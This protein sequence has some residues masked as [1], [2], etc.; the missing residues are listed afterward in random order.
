MSQTYSAILIQLTKGIFYRDENETL[1]VEL[2]EKQAQVR[3][4]F[5]ALYLDLWL[6]E[7]EGYAFLKPKASEDDSVEIPKLITRRQLS[8]H[9]SL[10]LALLRK[11]L[12]EF[13]S[14]GGA[15]RLVL[16][17]DEL[18]G[19]MQT[20]LP[21]QS[22]EAKQKDQIETLANKVVELGF[23]RKLKTT[24]D[25]PHFE[26]QRIIKAFIDA[27]WLNNFDNWLAACLESRGEK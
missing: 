14:Q 2:I 13:D 17:L 7:A 25:Q 1:W 16:S 22:N 4:Y 24:Q 3:D 15:T 20:F 11:Q 27:D 19:L 6:D 5:A 18:T 12:V 10:M 8:F 26:V 23:L 21:A 9:V